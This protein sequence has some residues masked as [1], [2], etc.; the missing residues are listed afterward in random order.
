M[1][2]LSE[3]DAE[4]AAQLQKRRSELKDWQTEVQ[5][6]KKFQIIVPDETAPG[7]PQVMVKMMALPEEA[8]AL[9]AAEIEQRL[10]GVEAKM[11]DL[12]V[13]LD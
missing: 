7:E 1:I 8:R 5:A 11:K 6:A 10:A 13:A 4:R 12:G 3:N 9:A 2:A